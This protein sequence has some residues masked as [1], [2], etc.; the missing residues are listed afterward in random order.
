MAL[1]DGIKVNVGGRE[2]IIPPLNLRALRKLKEKIKLLEKMNTVPGEEE[3]D[4]L[5]DIVTSAVQRNYP[6]ITRDNLEDLVDLAN[7]QEVVPAVL[8]ASGL[9]RRKEAA[10]GEAVSPVATPGTTLPGKS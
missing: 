3:I 4:A 8:A 6:E 10:P 7:L 2:L 5:L 1:L 9:V